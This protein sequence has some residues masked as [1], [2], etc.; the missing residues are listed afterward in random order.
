MVPIISFQSY[1]VWE[2][3]WLVLHPAGPRFRRTPGICSRTYIILN[4]HIIRCLIF[5]A[6][7]P[8]SCILLSR[9]HLCATWIREKPNWI[10][11]LRTLT[12]GCFRINLNWI[13]ISRKFLW[14]RLFI[15]LD[16]H[17]LLLLYAMRLFPVPRAHVTLVLSWIS[18]SLWYLMSTQFVNL[19]SS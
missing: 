17:C 14:Y 10:T 13:E 2:G 7:M 12:H 19:P 9:R 16:R 5:F 8:V 6:L 1:T 3:W 4:V 15:D 18:H 11:A